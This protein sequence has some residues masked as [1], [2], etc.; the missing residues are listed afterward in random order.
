MHERMIAAAAPYFQ[1]DPRS[2]LIACM[3]PGGSGLDRS[4]SREKVRQRWMQPFRS[5]LT[6]ALQLCWCILI[7]PIGFR[8]ENPTPLEIQ[9]TGA[10]GVTSIL[11]E[12]S[13]DRRNDVR[14]HPGPVRFPTLVVEP[15][16]S[17]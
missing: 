4:G 5:Y 3:N 10:H 17:G 14:S 7:Q 9:S 1:R 16:S 8:C 11:R 12:R 15:M 2:G 13:T 6:S